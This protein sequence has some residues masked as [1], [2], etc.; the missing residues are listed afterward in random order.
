MADSQPFL[1]L[2]ICCFLKEALK[3]LPH[4]CCWLIV[5]SSDRI[6]KSLMK[7]KLSDGHRHLAHCRDLNVFGMRKLRTKLMRFP[8]SWGQK[9]E[10]CISERVFSYL[11][12]IPMAKPSP[13][14]AVNFSRT[15]LGS[16][17][18]CRETS[19]L[20]CLLPTPLRAATEWLVSWERSRVLCGDSALRH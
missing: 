6:G 5:G 2:S 19:C 17:L 10:M 16:D 11:S 13:A 14:F 20:C 9:Q 1:P 4:F 8:N 18:L 3:Y 12:C 15:I 7:I